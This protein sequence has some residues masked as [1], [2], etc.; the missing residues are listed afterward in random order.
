MELILLFIIL[1]ITVCES[2]G[3]TFLKRFN[4]QAGSKY[5]YYVLGVLFYAVVCYLLI[6]SYKYKS[7]GIVNILWSGLSV[8]MVAS[9]GFL[10]YDEKITMID[11]VGVVFILIGMFCVLYEGPHA[12]GGDKK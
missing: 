2:I 1:C 6:Q 11:I 8:L 5:H 7:M 10:F 4:L 12:I 9:F 3:Q